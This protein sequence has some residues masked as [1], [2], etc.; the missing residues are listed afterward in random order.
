MIVTLTKLRFKESHLAANLANTKSGSTRLWGV[1]NL[2]LIPQIFICD[3]LISI[4]VVAM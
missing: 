1:A 4:N 2:A 3:N